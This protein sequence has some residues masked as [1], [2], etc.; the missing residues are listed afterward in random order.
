MTTGHA[1]ICGREGEG[2][3]RR[4]WKTA[5]PGSRG[6]LLRTLLASLG[7]AA[8]LIATGCHGTLAQLSNADARRGSLE[9]RI[10]HV[11]IAVPDLNAAVEWYREMLG[12]VPDS[13]FRVESERV[14][15]RWVRCG[16]FVVEIF[17]F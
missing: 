10:H 2:L 3:V 14:S 8:W 4:P 17:Q 7:A 1:L 9:L 6:T 12:C 15:L 16:D 5:I 11:A 13:S